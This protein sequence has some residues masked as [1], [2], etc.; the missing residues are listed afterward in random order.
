MR[1]VVGV[2]LI[3]VVSLVFALWGGDVPAFKDGST[4]DVV[5]KIKQA[6]KQ[7]GIVELTEADVNSAL[8]LY[9]KKKLEDKAYI[10]GIN[11]KLVTNRIELF[12]TGA[13]GEKIQFHLYTQG[14]LK[15]QDGNI[16]YTPQMF[17]MGRL[18]L[19][20]SMVLNKMKSFSYPGITVEGDSIVFAKELFPFE[21]TSF[22][23]MTGIVTIGI[24]KEAPAVTS[25]DNDT[26]ISV[27]PNNNQSIDGQNATDSQQKEDPTNTSQQAADET[28]ILLQEVHSQLGAVYGKVKTANEK[29]IIGTMMGTVG[30]LIADPNTAYQGQAQSVIAAYKKLSA[31]ERTDLK[32][33][34]LSTM[35]IGTAIKVKNLFGL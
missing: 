21:I 1:L 33:V 14:E 20:K 6:Q 34:M 12:V 22:S 11:C 15:E 5:Q 23:V 13:I 17:K 7:G 2:S 35:D 9:S 19:P 16:M 18:P 30:S 25:G 24:K 31:E 28:K 27:N 8:H 10:T 32:Q 26:R 3:I 4:L 29:A